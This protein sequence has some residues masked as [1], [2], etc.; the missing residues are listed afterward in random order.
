MRTSNNLAKIRRTG[1]NA[2]GEPYTGN[3]IGGVQNRRMMGGGNQGPLSSR[4]SE[5][6]R[7]TDAADAAERAEQAALRRAGMA[8]AQAALGG[9]TPAPQ[10]PAPAPA[11]APPKPAPAAKAATPTT[12]A[13]VAARRSKAIQDQ[14]FSRQ[15]VALEKVHGR[16]MGK[17]ASQRE[18][19]RAAGE[20]DQRHPEAEKILSQL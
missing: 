10:A 3:A 18:S 9:Q 14:N 11:P 1:L 6:Q 2:F 13:L 16:P 17:Y 8:R 4:P 15:R 12:P 7:R 19:M 20:L 5:N